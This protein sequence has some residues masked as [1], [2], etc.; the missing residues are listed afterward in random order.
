M[1][2]LG[3]DVAV[4]VG[5]AQRGPWRVGSGPGRGKR[6]DGRALKP[7]KVLLSPSEPRAFSVG[8][9][10][11]VLPPGDLAWG[12]VKILNSWLSGTL[13][14]WA[15]PALPGVAPSC[16]VVRGSPGYQGGAGVSSAQKLF[17]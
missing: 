3:R 15:H 17:C 5:G 7:R 2:T 12:T 13:T 4:G 14:C 6:R 1:Q 9:R 11:M 10:R 8:T 16:W